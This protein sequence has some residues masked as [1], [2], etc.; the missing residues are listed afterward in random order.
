MMEKDGGN[1]FIYTLKGAIIYLLLFLFYIRTVC[2]CG[3]SLSTCL[4][5]FLMKGDGMDTG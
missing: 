4:F 5:P 1:D 2:V 3:F